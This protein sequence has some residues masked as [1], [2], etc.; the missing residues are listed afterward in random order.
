MNH[1]KKLAVAASLAGAMICSFNAY[2]AD[3]DLD[4]YTQ[5]EFDA[6]ECTTV[7]K[8]DEISHRL[9]CHIPL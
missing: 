4:G 6:L 7:L 9:L 3:Y 2:A 1:W 5:E 8:S